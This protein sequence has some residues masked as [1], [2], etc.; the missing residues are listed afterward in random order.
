MEEYD[1]IINLPHHV[2]KNH[3]PMPMINRAAQFAPF[4]AL[5]GYDAVINE[6]GRLTDGFIELDENKKE[7]LNRKISELM[8]TMDEQPSVTITFFKPDE[9]KAGGSYS[10]VSGQLKKVDEY[11]QLLIL[12]DDTAIPFYRIFDIQ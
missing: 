10:T 8:E 12:K 7:Q 9:R 2:S 4:A 3:P 11:Q 6:T 1:D 5:T